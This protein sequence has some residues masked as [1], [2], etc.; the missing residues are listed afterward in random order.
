M[1]SNGSFTY[2]PPAGFTGTDT[3]T[4]TISD[5]PTHDASATL[6]ATVSLTVS[7][8]VWFINN[9]AGTN[10][11]GR[12]S[13]PFNSLANFQAVNDGTVNHPAANDHIFLYESATAYT[14]R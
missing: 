7:G 6:S 11:D 3:F 4:Y 10:G 1:S 13:S 12:L 14:G 9:T 8:M 5:G 2:D